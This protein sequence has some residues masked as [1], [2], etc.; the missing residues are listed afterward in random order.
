MN[1]YSFEFCILKY[2]NMYFLE[3]EIQIFLLGPLVN[4]YTPPPPPPPSSG[5]KRGSPRHWYEHSLLFTCEIYQTQ[6]DL[7]AELL[8]GVEY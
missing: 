3:E 1:D 8:L 6:C 5:A 2:L 7:S 4:L